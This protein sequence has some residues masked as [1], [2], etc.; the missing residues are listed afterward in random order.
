MPFLRSK[1]F[2]KVEEKTQILEGKLIG[3]RMDRD[4]FLSFDLL[5]S[6]GLSLF[7][8]IIVLL[9]INLAWDNI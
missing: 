9:F 2:G 7:L 8:I 4:Y 6:L 5:L 3:K 1:K